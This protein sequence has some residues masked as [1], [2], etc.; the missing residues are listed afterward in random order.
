VGLTCILSPTL[1]L[2][3]AFLSSALRLGSPNINASEARLIFPLH[4]FISKCL[5][6][7]RISPSLIAS[8]LWHYLVVF[9][10][11]CYYAGLVLTLNLFHSYFRVYKRVN[12]V[13]GVFH[14]S[15]YSRLDLVNPR[16]YLILQVLYPKKL[17]LALVEFL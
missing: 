14:Q 12:R 4:P 1:L 2:T 16:F 7:W 6:W 8:N 5:R 10:E 3:S 11:E 9:I 15:V 13:F 17:S